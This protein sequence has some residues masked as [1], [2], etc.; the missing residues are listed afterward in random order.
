VTT[1]PA[2][3]GDL[4]QWEVEGLGTVALRVE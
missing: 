4:I 3:A 1:K 2:R